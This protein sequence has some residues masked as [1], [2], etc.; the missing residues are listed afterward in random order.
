MDSKQ[1]EQLLARYWQC[2]T[3]LEEEQQLR[4]FFNGEDVPEHL[5]RYREVFVYP[6][7]LQKEGLGSDFDERVLARIETPRVVKARRQTLWARLMPLCKAAAAVALVLLLGNVMQH[8]L[9]AD[10][11]ETPVVDTVGRRMNAPS[12]AF[13]AEKAKAKVC[14]QQLRDSLQQTDKN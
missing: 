8:S 3:S 7:F 12:V 6:Q 10:A 11:P 1:I 9:V 4:D 5:L 13:S 2:E 14:D